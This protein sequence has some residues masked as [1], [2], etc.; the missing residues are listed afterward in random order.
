MVVL[1]LGRIPRAPRRPSGLVYLRRRTQAGPT[2]LLAVPGQGSLLD[3]NTV[4]QIRYR[5][6]QNRRRA[7]VAPAPTEKPKGKPTLLKLNEDEKPSSSMAKQAAGFASGEE[8][9]NMSHILTGM[10]ATGIAA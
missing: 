5:Q 9:G 2:V 4:P 1:A 3:A 8:V 7:A 6:T 10:G